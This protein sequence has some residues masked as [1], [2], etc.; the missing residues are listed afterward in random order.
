MEGYDTAFIGALFA[1]P[2]FQRD[3]GVPSPHG[4]YQVEAKWQ[5]AL[6]LSGAVGIIIGSILNGYLSEWFGMKRTMLVA[7]VAVTGLTFILVFAESLPIIL[8]GQILCGVPWGIFGTVA[9]A[10]ASEVCPVVLRGYLGTFINITWIIG[11]LISAGILRGVEHMESRWAY[12]ILFAGQW[13]WPVPLFIALVFCPESPWWLIRKNRIDDAE[14]ALT[15]LFNGDGIK[16][17]LAMMVHTHE[18]EREMEATSSYLDCFRGT[19]LRRTEIAFFVMSIQ[20][21][22]YFHLQ[23][24]HQ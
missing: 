20:P 8:L 2:A 12:A 4:G 6:N 17:R 1:E 5:T 15:R 22:A 14:H 23:L 16:E 10:Y 13:I 9:P 11:Q 18:R 21:R 19:D 24:C 3:F 7:Y